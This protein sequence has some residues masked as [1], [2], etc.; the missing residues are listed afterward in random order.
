MVSDFECTTCNLHF[1]VG[2][3]HFHDF[4]YG[5]AGALLA[6]CR[7]CS[8]QHRLVIALEDRGPEF[9]DVL[10]VTVTFVPAPSRTLLMTRL[11]KLDPE[12]SI[13]AAAKR[14]SET[15]F[16]YKD[17]LAESQARSI[18]KDLA[19]IGV[20]ARVDAYDKRPNPV[21]GPH[22]PHILEWLPEK[23]LSAQR[24]N[25]RK[26]WLSTEIASQVWRESSAKQVLAS[27]CQSCG[28]IAT[29]L[30]EWPISQGCPNCSSELHL[31][32]EWIT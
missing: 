29:L 12:M 1:S 14:I 18:S 31:E 10:R 23:A 15:P 26:D 20:E 7:C 21:F 6:I 16:T 3:Y 32:S 13:S 25:E 5:Y 27:P 24:V 28:G 4:S 19:R 30:T 22:L 8:T 9:Y 17:S 11:R 2:G